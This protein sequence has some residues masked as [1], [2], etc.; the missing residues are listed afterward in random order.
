MGVGVWGG[1][2][3]KT[4]ILAPYTVCKLTFWE[5]SLPKK[6]EK[7]NFHPNAILSTIEFYLC[8][9]NF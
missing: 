5:A 7:Q 8:Q 4:L 6:V 9:K 2:K 3:Y 1:L